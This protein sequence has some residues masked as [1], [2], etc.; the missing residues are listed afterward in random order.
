M[1]NRLAFYQLAI[2][3][4]ASLP[5]RVIIGVL[6]D[7]YGRLNLLILS[8]LTGAL[9]QL[10]FWPFVRSNAMVVLF[11]SMYGFAFGGMISLYPAVTSQVCGAEKLASK[12]GVVSFVGGM[13]GLL[14]PPIAGLWIRRTPESYLGAILFG[15][16]FMLF[17]CIW[18]ICQRLW[19]SRKILIFL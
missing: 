10:T 6:A 18:V 12:F 8:L 11:A 2:L 19:L 7:R 13:G 3:N 9:L 16:G 1:S 17:S 4:A 15:G 14:G 5:G